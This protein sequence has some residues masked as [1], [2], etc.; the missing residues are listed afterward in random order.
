MAYQ[1]E[2]NNGIAKFIIDRPERRNAINT[3]VVNGLENFLDR[4]EGNS[5]I[6]YVVVTGVGEEAFCSGGD[7]SE[8]QTL[9]TAEDAFPMLSRMAHVL[10]RL[11]T[12]PMP[13]IAL[14]NGT[15]VGGGCELAMACDYRVVSKKAKA[16]FIQGTLA[17]TT[18]WG[19]ATLLFE[20]DGKHDRVFKLLSEARL[21]SAEEMLQV[22]WATALFEGSA[23]EG[24]QQFLEKMSTIHPSVHRAYKKVAIRKWT[25][26]FLRDRMQEEAR[27]CSVLWESDAHHEAVARFLRKST[28]E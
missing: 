22:E 18:G 2:L 4:V 1:I 21:H 16:G 27:Q 25:A 13:V 9:W 12:L 24:L 15:A 10:F 23:E 7:L 3:E 26:D 5:D 20:K 19:G 14:V 11:A 17:I 6:S 8:Y 28:K